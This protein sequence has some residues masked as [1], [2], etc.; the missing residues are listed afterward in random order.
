MYETSKEFELGHVRNSEVVCVYIYIHL[1]F[2]VS[3][4]TPAIPYINNEWRQQGPVALKLPVSPSLSLWRAIYKR[5]YSLFNYANANKRCASWP[6]RFSWAR[7][8][9]AR[10]LSARFL[11]ADIFAADWT[12]RRGIS[13]RVCYTCVSGSVFF[14]FFFL[15]Q[16]RGAAGN[17]LSKCRK[18]ICGRE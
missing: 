17:W 9:R 4:E 5:F 6:Q 14:N 1:T 11:G 2:P 15:F 3:P 12:R 18:V 7:I 8:L 13:L 10:E 16:A